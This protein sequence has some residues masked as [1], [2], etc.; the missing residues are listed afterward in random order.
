LEPIS[1]VV[2]NAVGTRVVEQDDGIV[3]VAFGPV[4]KWHQVVLVLVNV[5]SVGAVGHRDHGGGRD[6]QTG[7]RCEYCFFLRR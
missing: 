5:D 4:E 2:L 3:E 1:D 7:S 6:F